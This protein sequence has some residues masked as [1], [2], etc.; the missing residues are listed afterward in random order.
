MQNFNRYFLTLPLSSILVVLI[1]IVVFRSVSTGRKEK[2]MKISAFLSLINCSLIILDSGR[3]IMQYVADH[4]IQKSDDFWYAI[5]A[6]MLVLIVSG[7][8]WGI[9][10]GLSILG[11]NI[12]FYLNKDRNYSFFVFLQKV[13]DFKKAKNIKEDRKNG[14]EVILNE[15]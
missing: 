10:Y 6:S 5:G 4:Q 8:L 13:S 9:L 2:C 3:G 12:A 14:K 15:S 11:L 7:I 1:A